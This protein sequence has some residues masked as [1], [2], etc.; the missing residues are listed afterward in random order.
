MDTC[1]FEVGINQ[2]EAEENDIIEIF[3]GGFGQILDTRLMFI[4]VRLEE[5]HEC[6]DRLG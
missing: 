2:T 4:S 1:A 5:V 3:A 6:S